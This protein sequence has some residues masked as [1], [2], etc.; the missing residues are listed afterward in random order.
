MVKRYNVLAEQGSHKS[1]YLEEAIQGPM[2]TYQA[3]KELEA[4]ITWMRTLLRH[5]MRETWD[6]FRAVFPEEAHSTPWRVGEIRGFKGHDALVNAGW[7]PEKACDGSASYGAPWTLGLSLPLRQ[8]TL[9]QA[10]L[11]ALTADA[12]ALTADAD[13]L[14][15]D[16]D[17]LT[18][19]ADESSNDDIPHKSPIADISHKHANWTCSNCNSTALTWGSVSTPWCCSKPMTKDPFE[20]SFID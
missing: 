9:V 17:A 11:D 10:R 5:Q 14:T 15:A 16:A 1:G 13:A 12:D 18:A 4:Q 7:K 3:Y 6:T 2:V 8:A 20:S 19:D